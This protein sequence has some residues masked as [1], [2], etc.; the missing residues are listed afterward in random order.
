MQIDGYY[1]DGEPCDRAL[2]DARLE[3]CTL[4]YGGAFVSYVRHHDMALTAELMDIERIM[5]K[6][7]ST[8]KVA[9]AAAQ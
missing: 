7:P 3:E 9:D 6:V 5:V 4:V 1:I 8:V 2:F